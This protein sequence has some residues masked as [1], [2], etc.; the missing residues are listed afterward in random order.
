MSSTVLGND[1]GMDAKV[2]LKKKMFGN[3]EGKVLEGQGIGWI[4]SVD[5][6]IIN[7]NERSSI[8]EDSEPSTGIIYE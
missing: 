3:E 2:R 8:Q 4:T 7:N 6:E 1:R 5:I